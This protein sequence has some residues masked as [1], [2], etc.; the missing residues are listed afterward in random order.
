MADCECPTFTLQGDSTTLVFPVPEW[1]QFVY[2]EYGKGYV[3]QYVFRC[4]FPPP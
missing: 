3:S 4:V 1:V 2:A